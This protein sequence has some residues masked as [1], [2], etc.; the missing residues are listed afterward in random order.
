[1]ELGIK[2]LPGAGLLPGRDPRQ[3]QGRFPTQPRGDRQFGGIA[4][5]AVAH[6]PRLPPQS[7]QFLRDDPLG[8]VLR[9]LAFE[10]T[11]VMLAEL[12][13]KGFLQKQ[14]RCAG[15]PY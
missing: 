1:M 3:R 10:F 12:A 5:G 14:M 6:L 11:G 7:L 15:S 13:F 9:A 4:F 8:L 2:A